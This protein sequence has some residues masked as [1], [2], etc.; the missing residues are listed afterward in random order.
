MACFLDIIHNTYKYYIHTYI[1]IYSIN[2]NQYIITHY[3]GIRLAHRTRPRSRRKPSAA[4]TDE[5]SRPWVTYM[6]ATMT[7]CVCR[8]GDDTGRTA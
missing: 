5:Q 3:I 8:M 7:F 1:Y 6:T 2:N 4:D